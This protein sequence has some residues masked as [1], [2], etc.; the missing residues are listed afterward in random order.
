MA[1]SVEPDQTAPV[2]YTVYPGLSVRK[3][4]IITVVYCN[5]FMPKLEEIDEGYWFRVVR[6]SLRVSVHHAF[7]ACHIL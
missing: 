5:G 2:V 7:V 1:V 4:M 3:L 6:P